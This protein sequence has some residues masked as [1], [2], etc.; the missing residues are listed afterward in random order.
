MNTTII[1][2]LSELL[3]GIDK[4]KTALFAGTGII[5]YA[6]FTGLPVSPL[7]KSDPPFLLPKSGYYEI[8]SCLLEISA[9]DNNFH[10]GFHLIDTSF[11]L[12]H[13]SQY[14]AAPIIDSPKVEYEFGSR[15]RAAF[16]GSFISSVVACGVISNVHAPTIFQEGNKIDPY[17]WLLQ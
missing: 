4:K 3:M 17:E 5:V 15:Y 8:E 16:Y 13:L 14:F 10:D 2:S 1:R 7:K 6:D 11:S 9:F 12:T